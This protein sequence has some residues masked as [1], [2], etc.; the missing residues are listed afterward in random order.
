[1]MDLAGQPV[2]PPQILAEVCRAQGGA[3]RFIR[4]RDEPSRTQ[5]IASIRRLA[6]VE[7]VQIQ[8][9]LEKRDWFSIWMIRDGRPANFNEVRNAMNEPGGI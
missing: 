8:T 4:Q 6:I 2:T 5:L 7:N 9:Q 1:M 3:V